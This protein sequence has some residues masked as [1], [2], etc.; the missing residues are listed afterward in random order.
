MDDI[1]IKDNGWYK[2][3]YNPRELYIYITI[4]Y[5]TNTSIPRDINPKDI[6]RSTC[7]TNEDVE[8]TG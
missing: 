7:I 2:L 4:E 1:I 3:M 5:N 6:V 8:I